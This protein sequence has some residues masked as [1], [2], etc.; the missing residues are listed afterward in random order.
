[1]FVTILDVND[2]R[3]IFLQSSYEAS[4]PEDIPEGHSI[5]QAGGRG[6]LGAAGGWGHAGLHTPS[7]ALWPCHVKG[8]KR[9]GPAAAP[10]VARHPPPSRGDQAFSFCGL[11]QYPGSP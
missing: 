6:P 4:I 9:E 2:N 5:V 1:M 3:P 8:W 7:V 11:R 10:E